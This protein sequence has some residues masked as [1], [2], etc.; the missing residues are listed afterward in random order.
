M[1]RALSRPL[2]Y[3]L[4]TKE[5]SEER[6]IRGKDPHPGVLTLDSILPSRQES[7]LRL[8]SNMA[9]L[10]GSISAAELSRYATDRR[11]KPLFNLAATRDLKT[12]YRPSIQP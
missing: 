9:G 10:H 4:T 6:D 3:L 11:A 2:A 12:V 7:S 5:E 8:F 1:S